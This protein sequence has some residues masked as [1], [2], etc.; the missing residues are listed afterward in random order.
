MSE[1]TGQN[2]WSPGSSVLTGRLNLDSW[3]LPL[4]CRV[5]KHRLD[6]SVFLN[7]CRKGCTLVLFLWNMHKGDTVSQQKGGCS[8]FNKKPQK[9]IFQDTRQRSD[10]WSFDYLPAQTQQLLLL[11]QR[12]SVQDIAVEDALPTLSS[13]GTPASERITTRGKTVENL[14]RALIT[15]FMVYTAQFVCFGVYILPKNHTT[16]STHWKLQKKMNSDSI[17]HV[18]RKSSKSVLIRA[19]RSLC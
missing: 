2:P 8:S 1:N 10:T 18:A 13:V 9:L 16:D 5:F 7:T 17:S 4:L 14:C 19:A 3:K 11:W 15:E 12:Q 6:S